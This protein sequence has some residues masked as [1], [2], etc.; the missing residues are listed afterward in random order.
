VDDSEGDFFFLAITF[1]GEAAGPG[2]QGTYRG[3]GDVECPS[4]LQGAFCLDFGLF[5]ERE[6]AL[7]GN[8]DCF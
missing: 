8:D 7:P 4:P 1:R 2:P 3:Q 6:G 5:L